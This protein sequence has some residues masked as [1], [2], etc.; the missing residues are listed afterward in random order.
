MNL[1][2]EKII[3]AIPAQELFDHRFERSNSCVNNLI[4]PGL[5]ILCGAPKSGKSFLALDLAIKVSAGESFLDHETT[6]CGVLYYALEDPYSRLQNR[7]YGLTEEVSETLFFKNTAET[8]KKGLIEEIEA[9]VAHYPQTR[10]VIIDTFQKV[11]DTTDLSYRNDYN[12]AGALK[13]LADQLGICILLVHHMRKQYDTD[14]FNM[15]SGTAGLTGAVDSTIVMVAEKPHNQKAV[16]YCTGRDI[17]SRELKLQRNATSN[18]WDLIAD[19]NS[20]PEEFFPKEINALIDFM[21]DKTFVDMGNSDL[22]NEINKRLTFPIATKSLK[23]SMNKHCYKLEDI[24]LYFEDHKGN[25]KRSVTITYNPKKQ[26]CDPV[27]P[28]ETCATTVTNVPID[29]DLPF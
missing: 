15:V 20:H 6:K 11:R 7:M 17:E 21:K 26:T 8:I 29:P 12:E 18:S 28:T 1:E 16:L 25:G 2:T 24:G 10:L 14:P 4:V 22:C 19:S 27:R 23:Q 9:F 3:S 5:T 13:K